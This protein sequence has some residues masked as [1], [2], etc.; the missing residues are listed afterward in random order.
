MVFAPNDDPM[1]IDKT[2]FKPLIEQEKQRQH[3]TYLCLYCGEP[4]HVDGVYPN[5]CVQHATRTTT[6]TTTQGPKEKG[7]KNIQYK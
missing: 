7:N 5:K 4:S 6:S 2:R 3:V 1:Q